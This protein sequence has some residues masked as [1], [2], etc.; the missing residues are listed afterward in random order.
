MGWGTMMGLGEA[1]T[2][3]GRQL[4]EDNKMK[5]RDKLETDREVARETRE[6]ASRSAVDSSSSLTSG[7]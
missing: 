1:F 3:I 7:A 4:D 5:L 6:A 2:N